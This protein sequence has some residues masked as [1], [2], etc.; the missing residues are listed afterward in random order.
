MKTLACVLL[1]SCGTAFA[2][3][4]PVLSPTIQQVTGSTC[5]FSE[6]LPSVVTGF[7]TDG[8]YVLSLARGYVACGHSGRGTNY[9]YYRW[10]G[11]LRFDLSGNFVDFTPFN[12]TVTNP[13]GF[14]STQCNALPADPSATYTNAGGYEA[15]SVPGEP[16]PYANNPYYPALS[17]P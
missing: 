2:T 1:M 10:C 8:N 13:D 15:Y 3:D 5:T 7:S 9:V 11:T 12:P 14:Q 4:V 16:F 17:S 6:L